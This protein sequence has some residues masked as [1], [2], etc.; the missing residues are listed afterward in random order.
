MIG[1]KQSEA[2]QFF[3]IDAAKHAELAQ[4]MEKAQ[5][6]TGYKNFPPPGPQDQIG[7]FHI[8]LW[9]YEDGD[10]FSIMEMAQPLEEEGNASMAH[11]VTYASR[12]SFVSAVVGLAMAY[13][14]NAAAFPLIQQCITEHPEI[15]EGYAA[16]AAMFAQIT[17]PIRGLLWLDLA[18]KAGITN[19]PHMKTLEEALIGQQ[20]QGMMALARFQN[21]PP[22]FFPVL[23]ISSHGF[24]LACGTFIQW[25]LPTRSYCLSCSMYAPF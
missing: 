8:F 5:K 4:A 25:T 1:T 13:S 23:T 20:K 19:H 22:V 11:V 14:M 12:R 6:K 18:K 17:S 15:P 21:V 9:A 16:A 10:W 24:P 2:E 7:L 3:R